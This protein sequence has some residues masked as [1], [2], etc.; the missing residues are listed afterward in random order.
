MLTWS[1]CGCWRWCA[2]LGGVPRRNRNAIVNSSGTAATSN[3]GSADS[4]RYGC[5]TRSIFHLVCRSECVGAVQMQRQPQTTK[6]PR[7]LRAVIG[8]IRQLP[9]RMA[10]R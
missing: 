9:I 4:C 3:S 2:E 10:C 8:E 1:R 7:Q 5:A 6:C